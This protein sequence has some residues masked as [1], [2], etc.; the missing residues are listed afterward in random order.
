MSTEMNSRN[1]QIHP[2]TQIA[3]VELQ[4]AD[5]ANMLAFY[6]DLLGFKLIEN[7]G[8]V[9]RLS[10]TGKPPT[11]VTLT[12]HKG[13]RPQPQFSTGLYHTAFRFPGRGPL[14]TTLMR[15]VAYGW[16]L[17]GASDHRVSEAIY[18]ADP[19]SNGIELYRDR[20][21]ADWPR[22]DNMVQM[23]NLPLDLRKLLEEADQAAALTGGIDPGTDIGHMHLQ[24]SDTA[25]AEAFYHDLLGLDVVMTMPTASFMSAGGYHHHLGANTWNSRNAAPR[26]EYMTGMR[27]YAYMIPDEAGW[28]ALFTRLEKSGQKLQ[29]T[30]RDERLGIAL[31]DQ[32]SNRVELLTAGTEAV[33]KNLAT[34]Q[35]LA[36]TV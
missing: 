29:A 23:G 5:L 2:D 6:S 32:D 20:P 17:Q 22:M 9:A 26:A 33:R 18:L 7:K 16:P 19:E 13:A 24:V 34:L 1:F 28:L 30:Q 14:A 25:T 21:R 15:L 11:L 27:S 31:Q 36:H 4:V 8:G 10:P 12:E 3:H 35:P